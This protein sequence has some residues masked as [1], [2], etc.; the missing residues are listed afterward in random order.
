MQE[1]QRQAE[2]L[3]ICYCACMG[4][5]IFSSFITIF[6]YILFDIRKIFNVKTGR[7]VRKTVKRMEKAHREMISE[8]PKDSGIFITGNKN[9]LE[10]TVSFSGE[11]TA[12]MDGEKREMMMEWTAEQAQEEVNDSFGKFKIQRCRMIVHTEEW[13]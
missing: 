6:F 8:N 2:I 10:E 4:I 13:I 7:S 3:H 9:H 1:I 12:E 11:E 5:G